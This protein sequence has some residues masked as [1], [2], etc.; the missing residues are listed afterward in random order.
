MSDM[1]WSKCGE[2]DERDN[3]G[4]GSGEDTG[5]GGDGKLPEGKGR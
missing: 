2:D 1:R 3:G 4:D 5:K